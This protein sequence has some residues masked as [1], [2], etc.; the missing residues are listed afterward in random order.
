MQPTRFVVPRLFAPD[1]VLLFILRIKPQRNMKMT[2]SGGFARLN[3]KQFFDELGFCHAKDNALMLIIMECL[4][5][6][7]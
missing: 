4:H 6:L 1:F 5:V 2:K 3:L 7:D